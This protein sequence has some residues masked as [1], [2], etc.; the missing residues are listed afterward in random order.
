MFLVS[1]PLDVVPIDS[2]GPL[3]R[4]EDETSKQKWSQTG[5]PNWCASQP[6]QTRHQRT[7]RMFFGQRVPLGI[8]LEFFLT[9]SLPFVGRF[10]AAIN[11]YIGVRHK[12]T[13][14][15][16]PLAHGPLERYNRAVVT[17]IPL[18]LA[19]HQKNCDSFVQRF[20]YAYNSQIHRLINATIFSLVWSRHAPRPALLLKENTHQTDAYCE[21]FVRPIRR[22]L[23]AL[24]S[25]V[26]WEI[27]RWIKISQFF[28]CTP[29]SNNRQM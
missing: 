24:S 11:T 23:K 8:I 21:K 3:T 26:E 29:R 16:N 20:A 28:S 13:W 12:T 18:C 9:N 22:E 10:L 7:L 14:T 25:A 6:E 19:E 2:F 5:N 15:Y 17:R 1:R 4:T 27:M